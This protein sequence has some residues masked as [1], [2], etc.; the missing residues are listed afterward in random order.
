MMMIVVTMM[1][2]CGYDYYDIVDEDDDND[3]GDETTT[4]DTMSQTI[5]LLN[6]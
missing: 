1:R 3:D 2:G 6:D 5:K 4:D